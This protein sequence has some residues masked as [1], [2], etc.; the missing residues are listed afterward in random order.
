MSPDHSFRCHLVTAW[1]QVEPHSVFSEYGNW[2]GY[3]LVPSDWVRQWQEIQYGV[4][5]TGYTLYIFIFQPKLNVSSVLH[6]TGT[7]FQQVKGLS[8]PMI[9]LEVELLNV[10]T[11]SNWKWKI[12][13]GCRQTRNT[14]ISARAWWNLNTSG[15][16]CVFENSLLDCAIPDAV[17][18]NR[19]WAI[20]DGGL[21]TQNA[22]FEAIF[23]SQQ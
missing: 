7:P 2:L 4:F 9:H 13:N 10:T 23:F 22:R 11:R 8:T 12:Q 18:C 17:K 1:N 6:Y 19:K 16:T 21:N 14:P 15:Y 3:S 5:K 20:Q